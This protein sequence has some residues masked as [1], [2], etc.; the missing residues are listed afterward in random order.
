MGKGSGRRPGEGYGDGFD[1]IFSTAVEP[2]PPFV[3]HACQHMEAGLLDEAYIL[4]VLASIAPEIPKRLPLGWL[5]FARDIEAE[6]LRRCRAQ[7]G[8]DA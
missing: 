3:A 5:K 1:R 4:K 6:V 8:N 2:S 7:G